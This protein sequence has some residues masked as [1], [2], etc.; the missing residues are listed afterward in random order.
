MIKFYSEK[1]LTMGIN[2]KMCED[3]LRDY[4]EKVSLD[5][6]SANE[7]I[8][9]YNITKY[10]DSGVKLE[11]WNE[12]KYAEITSKGKSLWEPINRYFRSIND[13]NFQ[14][15]FECIEFNYISDFFELFNKIKLYNVISSQIF[16]L[17]ITKESILRYAM[18]YK[19]IVKCYGGCIKDKLLANSSFV[20][21]IINSISKKAYHQRTAIYFPEEIT[22]K[23]MNDLF[24][25][26]CESE[27]VEINYLK[28]IIN[29]KEQFCGYKLYDIVRYKAK[30]KY[31]SE[32]EKLFSKSEGIR[33]D[34]IVVF[35]EDAN[36]IFKYTRDK[37][38]HK[39]VYDKKWFI[40]NVDFPTLLNN[41]IYIFEYVDQ[42]GIINLTNNEI[43]TGLFEKN[44]RIV[45]KSEYAPNS[46]F[47]IKNLKAKMELMFY[48][49]FLKSINHNV[50]SLINYFLT[51][52]CKVEHNI[53]NFNFNAC[54][55]NSKYIEKNRSLF[56]ELESVLKQYRAY[57][58]NKII[59]HK[60]IN[61]C[62]KPLNIDNCFSNVC[63]KYIYIKNDATILHN[64]LHCLF[65]DQTELCHTK[66]IETQ[67]DNFYKL[68]SCTD[69]TMDD[70][71]EHQ[72]KYIQFLVDERYVKIDNEG[73]IKLL[74][75]SV[76]TILHRLYYEGVL[77]Y[78]HYSKKSRDII[79]AFLREG[80]LE[81]ES[82][83]FTRMEVDYLNYYLND[84]GFI[85]SIGLRNKYQHGSQDIYDN[86]DGYKHD[87]YTLLRLF[88][89]TIIKINEDLNLMKKP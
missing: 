32:R 79:D 19:N 84:K 2:L 44:M 47:N 80:K 89:L 63:R 82:K 39:F 67:C 59:D 88:I 64:A 37:N 22:E 38:E 76:I 60:F 26:Y 3:F 1:D 46:S 66:N 81:A 29:F 30:L 87:Y 31:D 18:S 58:E 48:D 83:L 14:D 52:Y 57:V 78:W 85:D 53:S 12:D 27:H 40:E 54:S 77:S 45:L 61:F 5:S 42:Q 7:I 68:L 74:D 20:K 33:S 13:E 51:E 69:V 75:S 28:M 65:S 49:E 24:L 16:K 9:L 15:V 36:T 10:I 73:Y 62:S 34:I 11:Y 6:Y 17:I 50:E 72:Q 23:E 43:E 21:F 86:D 70:F 8:Q 56:A 55:T 41:F 71:D 4:N 25:N 35:S